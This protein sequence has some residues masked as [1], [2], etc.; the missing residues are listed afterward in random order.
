M[1]HQDHMATNSA[2]GHLPYSFGSDNHSG[3]HEDVMEAI[4]KANHSYSRAYGSD[5]W[6]LNAQKL[7]KKHF[8]TDTETFFVQTGTAANTLLIKALCFSHEAVVASDIAHINEDEC[9]APEAISGSKI[10]AFKSHMGKLTPDVIDE[11]M[12]NR[13]DPHRVVP[14]LLSLT[15]STELG[16]VYSVDELKVLVKKAHDRGLLAHIDGARIANAAAHLNCDLSD[17]T[18]AIG[19]DVLSFGGTKNGLLGGEAVVFLKKDVS[20]NFPFIRKQAMQ[21]ASKMRFISCQFIAYLTD[22]LWLR[23]AQTANKTAQYLR[24]KFSS[25]PEFQTFSFPYPTQA[26]AVFIEI[27]EKCR[28]LIERKASAYRWSSNLTRFVCSFNST[29]QQVDQLILDVKKELPI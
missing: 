25:E 5:P 7:F 10:L 15:Q 16:T 1:T 24:R 12:I 14:R 2:D 9:G 6:T 18:S 11:L 20:N 19:V 17:L 4:K 27:P 29:T 3:I 22:Q 28:D 13:E 21:L 26:N 8:G 23:N